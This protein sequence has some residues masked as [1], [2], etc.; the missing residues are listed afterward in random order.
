MVTKRAL[1]S[2]LVI[3]IVF[4]VTAACSGL[5][6]NG[7]AVTVSSNIITKILIDL[8]AGWH[9][10]AYYSKGLPQDIQ[11]FS[12]DSIYLGQRTKAVCFAYDSKNQNIEFKPVLSDTL[13]KTSAFLAQEQGDKYVCINGGF[14][15][16]NKSYSL[17]QYDDKVYAPNVK[18]LN[19][20]YQGKQTTYYPTRAAFGIDSFGIPHVSW[21]Y[22]VGKGNDS[23]Y[24][25]L[26]PSE[27][28][29]GSLPKPIPTSITPNGAAPWNMMSAIGGSPM[30][31]KDGLVILSD[32]AELINIDNHK[33][34]ARSAIGYTANKIVLLVAVEG[35]EINEKQI[36]YQGV[37]L[38]Q[39][40]QLMKDLNCTNAINLDGGGSTSMVIGNQLVV[41]PGDKG[42]ERSVASA[43]IIKRK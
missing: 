18:T 27:N 40:T 31:L 19:R 28:I 3:C 20:L 38:I 22:H 43:I 36:G 13:K 23:I 6:K 21:I 41:K 25:Y 10:N 15:G 30:L 34:R 29:V 1:I 26:K 11:V 39:L 33:P 9:C 42:V 12:F 35:G 4:L 32:T 2:S 24:S 5:K 8:P 7:V 16:G 14:F 17:V 37:N